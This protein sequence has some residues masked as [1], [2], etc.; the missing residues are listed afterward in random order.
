MSVYCPIVFY[1]NSCSLIRG[2]LLSVSA[3]MLKNSHNCDLVTTLV[4]LWTIFAS[5]K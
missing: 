4:T 1:T 2:A 3:G 5:M